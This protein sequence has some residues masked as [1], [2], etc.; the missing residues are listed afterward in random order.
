[1]ISLPFIHPPSD[2]KLNDDEIHVWK[3][4]LDQPTSLIHTLGETLSMEEKNRAERFHFEQDRKRFIACRGILRA[5]L[6]GYLTVDPNL[7]RFSYG[8]YGKPALS[9][10]FKKERIRFNLS[11]S[12]GLALYVFTLKREIGVDIEHIQDIPEIERIADQFFSVSENFVFSALPENKKK[13]AFFKYWTSKESFI[14]A[15]GESL[16]FSLN[17]FEVSLA[18]GEPVIIISNNDKPQQDCYWS[19]LELDPDPGFIATLAIQ[20]KGWRLKYWRWKGG[21]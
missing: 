1:M 12:E 9:D 16:C 15:K 17:K 13:R 18:L 21:Y 7:V 4:S 14:K 10:T 11:H 3:A 6:A 2:L 8:K 5:I 19:L 20:G